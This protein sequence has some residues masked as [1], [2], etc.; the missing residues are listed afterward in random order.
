MH[1]IF[2]AMRCLLD[3]RTLCSPAMRA[4]MDVQ[5]FFYRVDA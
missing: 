2:R 4:R 3:E 1:E 5:R